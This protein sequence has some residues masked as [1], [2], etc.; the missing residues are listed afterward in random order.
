MGW[1]KIR[2][3]YIAGGTSYRRLAEKYGVSFSTLR[4]VA[5][6]EQWTELRNKAGAKRDT[7]LVETISAKEAERAINIVDVADKL[8]GKI[9]V[10]V[11][12]VYDADSI[13]KLTSAI[14]D[15]K[16]IKGIKSD[17]DMREQ[18]ARIARLQKEAEA[19]DNTTTE[20]N[21]TFG[22]NN[23]SGKWAE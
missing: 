14:K 15:L 3:E 5:A 10:L 20:I 2:A 1:N 6:K 13:K 16:D 22:S 17:A 4:K 9:E 19:D 8:L 18:E 11:E 23:G 21:V 7:K 12:S